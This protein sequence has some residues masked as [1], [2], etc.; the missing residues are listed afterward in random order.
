MPTQLTPAQEQEIESIKQE[1]KDFAEKIKPKIS[2]L[3]NKMDYINGSI[4]SYN[5]D[6]LELFIN[7]LENFKPRG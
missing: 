7:E 3:V 6:R 2:T 1:C 5:I 4:Y